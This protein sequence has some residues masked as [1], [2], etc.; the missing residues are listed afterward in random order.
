M[1]P[2]KDEWYQ[3]GCTLESVLTLITN[4]DKKTRSYL[5]QM[6][7]ASVHATLALVCFT[8]I[9]GIYYNWKE[10][11]ERKILDL[12]LEDDDVTFV[13]SLLI[14]LFV[15]FERNNCHKVI[16]CYLFGY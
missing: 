15:I 3:N 6:A 16:S 1:W 2:L 5:K 14:R 10:L 4:I 9:F 7:F 8:N 11:G 13:G 12:M